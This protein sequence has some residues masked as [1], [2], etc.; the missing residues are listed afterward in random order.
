MDNIKRKRFESVAS[1][2]V[3]KVINALSS[4]QKCSNIYNYEYSEEDV[5]KMMAVL[6]K[7]MDE[8]KA[9]YSHGLS[10]ENKE[11]KF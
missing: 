9:S 5:R 11:F 7:Q 6:K 4:L 2:R 3:N 10:K 8:L 1:N